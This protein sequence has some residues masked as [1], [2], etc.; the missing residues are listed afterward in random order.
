MNVAF[1]KLLALIN[2]DNSLTGLRALTDVNV[3]AVATVNADGSI[4]RNTHAIVEAVAGKGMRGN[5]E[6]YYNRIDLGV[7]F[8][9]INPNVGITVTDGMTTDDLIPL[10]NEKYGTDFEIEDFTASQPLVVSADVQTVTLTAAVDNHAYIGSF[11]LKYGEAEL[12]LDSI[13]LITTLTGFNYPNGDITK[14]QAAIYSYNLDGS[15]QPQDFW[16]SVALGPVTA[17]FVVPFNQAFRVDEDWIFDM[18]ADTNPE[19]TPIP[20]MDYNLAGAVVIYNGATADAPAGNLIN[21]AYTNVVLMSL[22]P[23]KCANFGGILSVYY[24]GPAIQA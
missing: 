8:S 7:L 9:K 16:S 19:G 14:G 12:S 13:V 21:P 4:A 20:P 23:S 5:V 2:R 15:A 18:S 10:I 22:S 6:V 17:D 11:E 24:G 1:N 3:T